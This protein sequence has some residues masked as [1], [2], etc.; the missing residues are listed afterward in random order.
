[1]LLTCVALNCSG[2]S[3][4]LANTGIYALDNA[5]IAVKD[6]SATPLVAITRVGQRLFAAGLHGV[7]IY[8]LDNGVT[9]RQAAVPVDVTLTALYFNSAMQGWAV[10]H[11]GV[12]L[13]TSDGGLSWT[14]VVD[15]LDVIEALNETAALA[16]S[17]AP[18]T[19]DTL[20]KLRVAV[21]YR[22]AGPSK[23]FLTIGPCGNGILAAG[24]QDLAMFSADGGKTWQ[25]WISAINNPTFDNIY[26]I[27]LLDN[28]PILIGEDGLVL[29]GDG[30]CKNF[31]SVPG[32]YAATLFGAIAKPP[33]G[34]LLYG[35][36][37]GV[38]LTTD[39]GSRW[40]TISLNTDSVID[41]GFLLH[42]GKMLLGSLNGNLY[43]NDAE[44]KSL[45]QIS[46]SIPFEIADLAVAPNGD[47][48]VV[49]SGGIRI[50][51]AALVR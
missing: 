15:G 36:D 47:L 34:L 4:A 1:L 24:Q 44:L 49:G 41:T 51:P 8:S 23:P 2:W 42:S 18:G 14:R 29:E 37:G 45:H 27:T 32:P 46:V 13:Q 7:I 31:K 33:G 17:S 12:V 40:D 19:Q 38:Y 10:G 30:N 11:F 21:A 35:I 3:E 28:F 48:V 5:A 43:V 20:L 50:V 26:A 22:Q 9:W 6:P 25:Q 39:R 16:Q